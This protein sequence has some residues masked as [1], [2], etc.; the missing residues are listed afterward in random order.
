MVD[1]LRNKAAKD[2]TLRQLLKNRKPLLPEN[3]D[4]SVLEK[5]GVSRDRPDKFSETYYDMTLAVPYGSARKS[6]KYRGYRQQETLAGIHLLKRVLQVLMSE[7]T[8]LTVCIQDERTNKRK[9]KVLQ[10]LQVL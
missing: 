4:R 10:K 1:W 5:P 8:D 9:R 6:G 2:S 3:I 7:F